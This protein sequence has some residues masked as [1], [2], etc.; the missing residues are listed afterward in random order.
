MKGAHPKER[1]E[2]EKSEKS[3]TKKKKKKLGREEAE[4]SYTYLPSQ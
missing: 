4:K 3:S 2:R 1:G